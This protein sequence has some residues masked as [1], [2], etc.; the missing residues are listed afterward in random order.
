MSLLQDL[1][2][3]SPAARP[4]SPQGRDLPQLLWKLTKKQMFQCFNVILQYLKK[5][6]LIVWVWLTA[7]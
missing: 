7:K 5:R 3:L 1:R 2:V 4:L 6:V